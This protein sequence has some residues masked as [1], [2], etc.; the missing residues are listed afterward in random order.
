MRAVLD[1]TELAASAGHKVTVVTA[2]DSDVPASWR[3]I[4]DRVHL[5]S[6]GRGGLI[7]KQDMLGI[8]QC[9][10][11]ADVVHLHTPWEMAN[12]QLAK[13]ALKASKPYVL[14]IHGMLDDWCMTQRGLKK[15][16]YL[17]LFGKRLL[18]RAQYVHC[19]A[20]AELDQSKKYFPKGRGVIVPNLL[21]MDAYHELPGPD[22]ARQKWSFLQT[23]RPVLL[24]LSRIHEKK[25]IEHLIS[26]AKHLRDLDPVVVVA[27]T[28][29]AEYTRSLEVLA[30]DLG[31]SDDVHF[32]GH[33]GGAEKL[34]L[35][36]AADVFVLPTSQE[37]FGFVYFE[38]LACRTPIVTTRGTDTWPDLERSGAARITHPVSGAALAHDIA[39][40]LQN[41]DTL[42][43]M[44]EKGRSWVFEYLDEAR[45]IA[46]YNE[47][48]TG[49]AS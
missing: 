24:F 37:N 2:D 3:D 29:D 46:Q 10:E 43:E 9:V 16:I 7:R 6:T 41:R 14:T 30:E 12:L 28:G 1:M 33:I 39:E 4:T 19:S 42:R 21:A 35:Y 40:M 25:G 13:I 32:V 20:Q 17:A 5:V 26:S 22:I 47:M 8:R 38:S 31:V 27:G 49:N 48:Y 45:I 36:E 18:E 44:G 23:D 34:S 11:R 15:K